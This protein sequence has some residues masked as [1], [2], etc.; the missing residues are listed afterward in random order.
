MALVSVRPNM[1][2]GDLVVGIGTLALAGFTWLVA[3]RTRNSIEALDRPFIFVS[4]KD[5]DSIARL[6]KRAMYFSLTNLGKGPGIVHNVE[7][8][9]PSGDNLFSG[10]LENVRAIRPA[11]I[12]TV[13]LKMKLGTVRPVVGEEVRLRTLYRSA[14]NFPYTTDSYLML[15]TEGDFYYRGHQRLNE[16]RSLLSRIWSKAKPRRDTN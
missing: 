15:G 7:L 13:R 9:T 10:S 8:L 11:T 5:D 16:E 2:A 6:G 3:H 4:R 1:T 12:D 14:S